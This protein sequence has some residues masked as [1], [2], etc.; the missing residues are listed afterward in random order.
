MLVYTRHMTKVRLELQV[1]SAPI[2]FSDGPVF[3]RVNR[4][5]AGAVWPVP[6]FNR[7]IDRLRFRADFA[8][9]YVEADNSHSA[10]VYCRWIRDFGVPGPALCVVRVV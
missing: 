8:H 7:R 9:D 5:A 1:L 6:F 4:A 2:G 3:V 10:F